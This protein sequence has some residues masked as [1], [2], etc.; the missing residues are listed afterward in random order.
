[1]MRDVRPARKASPCGR[2]RMGPPGERTA[3]GDRQRPGPRPTGPF[4]RR[5][6]HGSRHGAFLPL[7]EVVVMPS[8]VRAGPGGL[9]L[10]L[11]RRL[12]HLNAVVVLGMQ[13]D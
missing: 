13:R 12:L 6:V 8:T 4:F 2:H 11:P 10:L 1:M 3:P 7:A 9:P 5:W